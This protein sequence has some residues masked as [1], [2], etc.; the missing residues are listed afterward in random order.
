MKSRILMWIAVISVCTVPAMPYQAFAQEQQQQAQHLSH[1]VVTDLGTL[2]GTFS[3]DLVGASGTCAAYDLRYGVPLQPQHALLWR[4]GR[5]C[6]ETE[7]LAVSPQE[8]VPSQS[9]TTHSLRLP[10]TAGRRVRKVSACL[11]AVGSRAELPRVGLVRL[12]QGFSAFR[13]CQQVASSRIFADDS[14]GCRL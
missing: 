8:Q 5:T 2:G 7:D 10:G 14:I 4:K 12:E 1:Y 11:H 3:S 6:G 13:S 9:S